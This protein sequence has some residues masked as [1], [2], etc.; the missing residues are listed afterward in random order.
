M[1]AN[2]VEAA[3]I[4]AVCEHVRDIKDA[5]QKVRGIQGEEEKKAG[6][7]KWFATDLPEWCGKLEK[8]W[9]RAIGRA[10]ARCC[11]WPCSPPRQR[12]CR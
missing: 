10:R 5:Y 11:C 4:D 2:E 8:V 6:M 1:G 3:Q 12:A 9:R 7:E